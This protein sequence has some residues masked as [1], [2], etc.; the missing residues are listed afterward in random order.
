MAVSCTKT[1]RQIKV[2]SFSGRD[3]VREESKRIFGEWGLSACIAQKS[4]YTSKFQLGGEAFRCGALLSFC[5]GSTRCMRWD[6]SQQRQASSTYIMIQRT[7]THTQRVLPLPNAKAISSDNSGT[8]DATS[9]LSEQ[10][11]NWVCSTEEDLKF[12]LHRFVLGCCHLY[13]SY[14]YTTCQPLQMTLTYSNYNAKCNSPFS[15]PV[16][17]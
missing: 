2:H 16:F 11:C 1:W 10:C 6:L 7:H 5:A 9:V 8:L 12:K 15:W 4:S 13:D 3:R 14:N 17:I